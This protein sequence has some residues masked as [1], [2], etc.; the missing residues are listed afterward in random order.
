MSYGD[1][2]GGGAAFCGDRRLRRLRGRPWWSA[3]VLGIAEF[4][5]LSMV[6]CPKPWIAANLWAPAT[7]SA[8]DATFPGDPVG[9]TTVLDVVISGSQRPR[10]SCKG[11][12][13]GAPTAWVATTP[14]GDS[15][16]ALPAPWA[17]ATHP[18]PGPG[19]SPQPVARHPRHVSLCTLSPRAR[20]YMRTLGL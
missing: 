8:S 15:T 7:L 2:M 13:W 19:S 16:G 18:N 5:R 17:L 11:S 4:V 9:F 12:P 20:A 6:P 14:C 3:T 10:R 1:P